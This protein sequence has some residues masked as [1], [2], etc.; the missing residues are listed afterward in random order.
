MRR[1]FILNNYKVFGLKYSFFI[2]VYLIIS[3]VFSGVLL[4]FSGDNFIVTLLS[5]L[6]YSIAVLLVILVQNKLSNSTFR[7]ITKPN[8]SIKFLLLGVCLAVGMFF[9]LGGLNSKF[10][11]FLQSLNIKVASPSLELSSLKNYLLYALTLCL[12]P[13][14][15]E[16]L[17]FRR[18]LIDNINGNHTIISL[19]VGLLFALYHAALSQLIYQ[20]IYGF[21]L[22]ILAL[23]SKSIL[24]CIVAHFLNNFLVIT[25]DFF[26][27]V[28]DFMSIKVMAVGLCFLVAFMAVIFFDKRSQ[29]SEGNYLQMIGYSSVGILLLVVLIVAGCF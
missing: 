18:F 2:L 8:F 17:F 7:L 3:V 23:K 22:T 24:P 6:C 15:M 20:F 14:L 27:V 13:A 5:P 28:I 16:E 21:F 11:E 4:A 29:K 1:D 25:F 12:L 19:V 26:G 10:M 9:G